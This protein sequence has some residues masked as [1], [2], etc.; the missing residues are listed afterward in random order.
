M[1]KFCF[2]PVLLGGH[3]GLFELCLPFCLSGFV[4]SFLSSFTQRPSS[5]SLC[6]PGRLG[7]GLSLHPSD[8]SEAKMEASLLF[9]TR[10]TKGDAQQEAG[11]FALLAPTLPVCTWEIEPFSPHFR[12][13]EGRCH[14]LLPCPYVESSLAH[15]A[16]GPPP[17][18]AL[19]GRSD[20]VC[21]AQDTLHEGTAL[22]AS[23]R[24]GPT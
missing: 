4:P 17:G 9:P 21:P 23:S 3:L 20:E 18:D 14:S 13:R 19:K 8:V 7:S 22:Q 2:Q 10:P 5:T 15:G 16:Q 12:P 11:R 1:P 24:R 6:F